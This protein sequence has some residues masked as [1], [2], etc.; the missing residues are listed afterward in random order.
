[1]G[2][3]LTRQGG[4]IDD[5]VQVLAEPFGVDSRSVAER[6]R[7]H[8]GRDETPSAHRRQVADNGAVAGA[9]AGLAAVRPTHG[10]TFVAQLALS[11]FLV[12]SPHCSP[13]VTTGAGILRDVPSGRSA[14]WR[15]RRAM[16][17]VAWVSGTR[18]R[19]CT[20]EPAQPRCPPR[21]T[22]PKDD[23][24]PRHRVLRPGP[25]AVARPGVAPGTE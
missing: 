13:R 2:G 12:H 3:L 25:A 21:R 9:T 19:K 1:L 24:T 18:L 23:G 4:L 8:V 16:N 20:R 15:R 5:G 14:I 10:L 11:G 7:H 6:C 22:P 17:W